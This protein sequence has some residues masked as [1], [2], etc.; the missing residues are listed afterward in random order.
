ML[1]SCISFE[2]FVTDAVDD[3]VLYEIEIGT[4]ITLFQS[5]DA[6]PFCFASYIE[7]TK[8]EILLN[9]YDLYVSL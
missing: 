5:F 1:F 7:F 2:T 4:N 8:D 3:D 9:V 6:V